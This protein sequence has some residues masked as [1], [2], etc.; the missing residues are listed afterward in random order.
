M[1]SLNSLKNATISFLAVVIGVAFS[2]SFCV[3]D[4]NSVTIDLEYSLN[5]LCV[6]DSLYNLS[7]VDSSLWS[8]FLGHTQEGYT[9]FAIAFKGSDVVL[10]QFGCVNRSGFISCTHNNESYLFISHD[11]KIT[12]FT[13]KTDMKTPLSYLDK[14]QNQGNV[15]KNEYK[16]LQNQ[17]QRIIVVNQNAKKNKSE[18]RW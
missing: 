8:K 4:N 10:Y 2:L 7:V 17:I 11:K 14:L 1:W 16:L 5:K 9:N 6:A 13:D 3:R 12:L 15:S 18:K